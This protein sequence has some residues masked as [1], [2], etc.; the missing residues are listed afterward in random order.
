M[1]SDSS[2]DADT[3]DIAN[4]LGDAV[5]LPIPPHEDGLFKHAASGPVLKF[6]VENPTVNISIRQ[7]ARVTPVSER[8]TATAIETLEANDLVETFHVGNARRVQ[9]NRS[10]LRKTRDP[11][12]NIPQIPYRTPVRIAV[13]YIE[14]EL[15][16]VLGIVC[17]GSVARGEADR[18]SDIDLW[19]LVAD[20]ILEQRNRA[21]KLA[22]DLENLQIPPT[23]AL[24]EARGVNFEDN[25]PAIR[26]KLESSD[27]EW[28]SAE[29]HSFEFLVETPESIITK[30]TRVDPGKLFGSGITLR[31][32]EALEH[33]RKEVVGGE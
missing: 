3:I 15:D 10:R 23:I 18:R 13:Q 28:D 21:Q 33:V 16:E 19:I 4:E 7:L 31:T 17:F 2:A 27:Q 29:R 6:L 25:W 11:I 12:T 9:I 22:R 20:D 24:D 1:R 14:N 26:K 8:A 30:S 32:S 5:L